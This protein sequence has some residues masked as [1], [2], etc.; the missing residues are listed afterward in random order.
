MRVAAL[1]AARSLG[2][3]SRL[4]GNRVILRVYETRNYHRSNIKLSELLLDHLEINLG[5]E[6]EHSLWRN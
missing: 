5:Q 3:I 6:S 4:W 1:L 2:S